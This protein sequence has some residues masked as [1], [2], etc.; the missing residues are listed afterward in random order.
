MLQVKQIFHK[1]ITKSYMYMYFGPQPCP[2]IY[3]ITRGY[4]C[5]LTAIWPSVFVDNHCLQTDYVQIWQTFEHY[6]QFFYSINHRSKTNVNMF[7]PLK[8]RGNKGIT[9]LSFCASFHVW[10]VTFCTTLVG[11]LIEWCLT[12]NGK[13]FMHIQDMFTMSDVIWTLLCTRLRRWAQVLMC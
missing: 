1:I 5:C 2:L 4:K 11:W 7:Y 12:S 8:I 6:F 9:F 13:Y 3:F 10:P